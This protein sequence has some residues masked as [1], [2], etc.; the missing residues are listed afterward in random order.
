MSNLKES[1]QVWE[2]EDCLSCALFWQ[3][4]SF[5]VLFCTSFLYD[6]LF[7]ATNVPSACEVIGM[8]PTTEA[9]A[10]LY[11]PSERAILNYIGGQ[12]TEIEEKCIHDAILDGGDDGYS[13]C[14]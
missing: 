2:I 6:R 7:L 14:G 9:L 5:L 12:A 10:C 3:S 11:L 4:G 13:T 8:W 1:A